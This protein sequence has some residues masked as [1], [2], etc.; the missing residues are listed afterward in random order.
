MLHVARKLQLLP[1]RVREPPCTEA[2]GERRWEDVDDGGAE[3][4]AAEGV[5]EA[6]VGHEE[7]DA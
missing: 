3:D 2:E 5:D 7:S 4:G 6:D 1:A